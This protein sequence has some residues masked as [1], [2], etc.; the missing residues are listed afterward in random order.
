MYVFIHTL[1]HIQHA[2]CS[3][4]CTHTQSSVTTVLDRI[5]ETLLCSLYIGLVSNTQSHT[6]SLQHP[7]IQHIL[8]KRNYKLGNNYVFIYSFICFLLG[9]HTQAIGQTI[10]ITNYAIILYRQW[11]EIPQNHL[12]EQI[13]FSLNAK[14]F[15]TVC[16]RDNMGMSHTVIQYW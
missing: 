3:S 7:Y 14:V 8:W 11:Y 5:G 10:I 1:L 6:H 13:S 12:K 4:T 2:H 15:H 16:W 9:E